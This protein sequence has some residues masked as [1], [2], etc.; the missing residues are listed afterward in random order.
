MCL[1]FAP[2]QLAA[3]GVLLAPMLTEGKCGSGPGGTT[4]NKTVPTAVLRVLASQWGEWLQ[5]AGRAN[6]KIKELLLRLQ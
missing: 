5:T 3:E 2:G 1:A 4:V 6:T